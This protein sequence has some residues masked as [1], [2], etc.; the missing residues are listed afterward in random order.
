M[1][2]R[3]VTAD[4]DGARI[5]LRADY[6]DSLRAKEVPGAKWDNKRRVWR[7]PL[8]WA[9]CIQ[10]RGV[11]GDDLTIGPALLEWAGEEKSRRVDRALE[12]RSAHDSDLHV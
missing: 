9:S 3:K 1:G 6:S 4:T 10:L 8:S 12:A 11:F 5:L 2:T 7:Y